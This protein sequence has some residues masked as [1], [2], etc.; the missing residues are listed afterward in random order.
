M[1]RYLVK[2]GNKRVDGD[3]DNSDLAALH[4]SSAPFLDGLMG[5]NPFGPGFKI[6]AVNNRHIQTAGIRG[7]AIDEDLEFDGEN[8]VSI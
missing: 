5:D 2:L 7:D 1:Q 6:V 3:R 4:A 8:N